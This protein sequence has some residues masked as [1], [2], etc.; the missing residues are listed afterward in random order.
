[1]RK[2]TMLTRSPLLVLLLLA[3][4]S[5]CDTEAPA[6]EPGVDTLS[7]QVPEAEL[8]RAREVADALGSELQATLLATLQDD[9]PLGAVEVC[10]V[11]AQEI[12][13]RHTDDEIVTRR[14]SL[15]TR[16]PVNDPDP[17]EAERLEALADA[18]ER[19]EM[20]AEEAEL[21]T[22][23]GEQ[24]L[25]YL[26]PIVIAEPCLTC[27][28]DPGQIDPSVLE[29]IRD[30]YPEDRAVGYDAGDFRGIVSVRLRLND[31]EDH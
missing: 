11:E 16:N 26:R 29:L 22:E 3:L 17:Y 5:A 14:T 13:R 25:R 23:N 31:R 24:V 4:A 7:P 6:P 1:M 2:K 21:R 30:E 20:P 10:A 8:E 12:S 19:G 18:H 27:H 9:G 15:L 28:G